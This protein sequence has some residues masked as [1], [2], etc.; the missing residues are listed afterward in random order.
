MFNEIEKV[1]EVVFEY[2]GSE[3]LS[4]DYN[5]YFYTKQ[6]KFIGERPA[7]NAIKAIIVNSIEELEIYFNDDKVKHYM[8][9]S[10]KIYFEFEKFYYLMGWKYDW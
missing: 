1:I 2:E 5:E 7:F 9:N 4:F 8:K 6:F 10:D 3:S